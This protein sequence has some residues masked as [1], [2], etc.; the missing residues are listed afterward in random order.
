M[1]IFRNEQYFFVKKTNLM[2]YL[3][4][5][6]FVNLHIS[7]IFVAHHQEVYC[8]YVCIFIYIQYV[9]FIVYVCI[10]NNNNNNNNNIYLLQ[11]G[12]YPVTVVISHVNKHEIGYY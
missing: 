9:P 4:L 10:Y 11:F 7:G 1:Y 12:C 2:H 3:A 6:Y 5:F 8:I